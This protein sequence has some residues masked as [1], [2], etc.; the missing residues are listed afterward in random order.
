M[1]YIALRQT[2][3]MAKLVTKTPQGQEQRH[4]NRYTYAQAPARASKMADWCANTAATQILYLR[5]E[6]VLRENILNQ[7]TALLRR[8]IGLLDRFITV[9]KNRTHTHTHT[10]THTLTQLL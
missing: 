3:A 9:W 7:A 2:H 1:R 8:S 6:A 10:H 4:V 5:E